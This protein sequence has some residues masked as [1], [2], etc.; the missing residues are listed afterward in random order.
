MA[1]IMNKPRRN[2]LPIGAMYA[3]SA[4]PLDDLTATHRT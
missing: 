2:M 3:A 4:L 1:P